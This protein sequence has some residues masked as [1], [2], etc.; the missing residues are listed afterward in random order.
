MTEFR[1]SSHFRGPA[2]DFY[3]RA[4]AEVQRRLDEI[5]DELERDP[6]VDNERKFY[7]PFPPAIATAYVDDDFRIVYHVSVT[8]GVGGA[9]DVWAIGRPDDPPRIR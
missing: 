2:V 1:F 5:F 4:P 3:E 9:I 8:P 6:F 7:F